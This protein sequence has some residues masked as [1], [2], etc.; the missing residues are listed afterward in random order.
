[1]RLTCQLFFDPIHDG[2]SHQA[3]ASEV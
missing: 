1:L 3:G 2:F